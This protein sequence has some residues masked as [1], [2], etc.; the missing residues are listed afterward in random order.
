MRKSKISVI[1]LAL[2]LGLVV[3]A[4]CGNGEE[5]PEALLKKYAGNYVSESDPQH[6][7]SLQDNGSFEMEIERG[8]TGGSWLIENGELYLSAGSFADTMEISD[9]VITDSDGNRFLKQ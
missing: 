5:D 3:M 6:Y 7:I 2:L 4:G 8:Y 9:G 1:L